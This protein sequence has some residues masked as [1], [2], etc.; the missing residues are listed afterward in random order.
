MVMQA[1]LPMSRRDTI[2]Y[3]SSLVDI[4]VQ[5]TREGGQRRIAAIKMLRA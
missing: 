5:L 1:G 4:V 3:V 2:D